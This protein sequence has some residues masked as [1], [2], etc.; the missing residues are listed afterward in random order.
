MSKNKPYRLM[1]VEQKQAHRARLKRWESRNRDKVLAHRREYMREYVKR[2]ERR[3]ADVLKRIAE[4]HRAYRRRRAIFSP[5]AARD[6]WRRKCLKRRLHLRDDGGSHT[7]NEWVQ[8]K[9]RH[10]YLCAICGISEINTVLT[11]DH[12]IPLSKGG[13]NRIE[14]IQ[15]LCRP[16][17][18]RKYNHLPVN[19]VPLTPLAVR[20]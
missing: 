5:E 1:T 4:I 13:S 16:C 10:A 20:A 19:N 18:T 14:N 6:V 2:P 17:N 11:K 9:R 8:V 12:I 7:T 15:P 3:T